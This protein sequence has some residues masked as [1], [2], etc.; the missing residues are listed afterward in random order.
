MNKRHMRN[1][2]TTCVE[3]PSPGNM[4]RAARAKHSLP[5]NVV[6]FAELPGSRRVHKGRERSNWVASWSE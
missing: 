1:G 3:C 5:K 6:M 4:L 2:Q